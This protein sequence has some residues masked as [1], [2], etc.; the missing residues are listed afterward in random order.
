LKFISA[1]N[2]AIYMRLFLSN[3]ITRITTFNFTNMSKNFAKRNSWRLLAD[4]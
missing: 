3:K 4:S 1:V 2:I